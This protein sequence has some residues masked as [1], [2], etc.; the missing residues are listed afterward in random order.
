MTYELTRANVEQQLTTIHT[1]LQ[2]LTH[3]VDEAAFNRLPDGGGGWSIAQCLDHLAQTT[4][5]YGQA[6]DAAMD[7]AP[8]MPTGGPA[9]PNLPGRLLIWAIEP[10]VRFGVKAIA[11]LTPPATL[12]PETVRRQFDDSLDRLSAL[13]DRALTIDAGRTRYQ[14]PLAG[15]VRLFNVVTGVMVMLAHN[16][17]HLVHAE[18]VRTVVHL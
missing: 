3:G 11:Q 9:M 14:N 7:Q 5:L 15:G 12:V 4:E 16:R 17:R 8:P 2:V 1:R 6:L 10:P 18:R 13:A